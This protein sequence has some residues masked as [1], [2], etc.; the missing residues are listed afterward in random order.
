MT[1][2]DV[3]TG[4]SPSGPSPSGPSPSPAP[5]GRSGAW[6]GID[7]LLWAGVVAGPLFAVLS[8]AQVP[9]HPGFDLTRNAFS[10]L[11][12]GPH[13]RL[14]TLN[15]VVAGLL[16]LV[17]AGGLGGTVTGRSGRWARGLLATVGTGMTAGGLFP[18]DPAM[19]YPAG[20]PAG[21]PDHVSAVSTVHAVAFF[22][23][24]IAWCA[25][26]AVLAAHLH[27]TGRRG[28]A[29]AAGATAAAL[30]VIPMVSTQPF[31]TVV[32]YG[33][34]TSAWVMMSVLFVTLGR[35]SAHQSKE[36]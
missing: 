1:S 36:S 18:P 24:M 32:L 30:L 2:L 3:P 31:G 16:Y 25:L 10:F 17:A 8:F 11:L 13:G 5:A 7:P 29:L 34:A 15:F 9:L 21:V 33:V 14:Q 12:L 19:G 28:W 6:R 35:S 20:A 26:L 27:R 23:S 22:S 4:S